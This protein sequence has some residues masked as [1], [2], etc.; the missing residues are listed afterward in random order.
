MERYKR[1]IISIDE[2]KCN[3]CGLCVTACHEG[4]IQMIDGKA[5]MMSDQYCDGL[6]DCLPSCPTGAIT[7]IER[8]ADAYNEELVMAKM[9]EKKAAEPTSCEGFA[10]AMPSIPC[11]C[12]GSAAQSIQ[13]EETKT[14]AAPQQEAVDF[15]TVPS[16]LKQ[17]PVELE[18]INPY[19]DYLQGADLLIA[20]DCT[21]YAYGNFHAEFIKGRVTVIGCPKLDNLAAHTQKLTEIVKANA[22]KSITVV[23]MSVPCCGGIVKAAQ[24]AMLNAQKI[25]PY[26]EVVIGPDG[27]IVSE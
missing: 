10:D 13:R 18:L 19:A 26:R 9:A 17:W 20:A 4:A 5:K 12:P 16:Q 8:E 1:T 7:M 22:L 24:Q 21:A 11:G 6:G 23:R 2:D 14:Q 27:T 3:G 15:Q 25:V